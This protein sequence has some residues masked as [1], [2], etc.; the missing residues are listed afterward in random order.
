MWRKNT[1]ELTS[2]RHLR[3]GEPSERECGARS[4]TTLVGQAFGRSAF[5]CP[6]CGG[7]STEISESH[8][9]PQR[10]APRRVT[11]RPPEVTDPGYSFVSFGEHLSRRGLLPREDSW[12]N[13]S[14]PRTIASTSA[15]SVRSA[16]RSP[17]IFGMF[18]AIFESELGDARFIELAQ[19][20]CD[21]AFILILSRAREW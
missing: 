15:T 21:H 11:N 5:L 18:M 10:K 13:A 6:F 19:S 1:S 20:F 16:S 17:V 7:I 12:L 3:Q 14:S 4:V 9:Y 8:P 2:Q